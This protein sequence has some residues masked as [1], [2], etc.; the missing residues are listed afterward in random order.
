MPMKFAVI[1]LCLI[2]HISFG[3]FDEYRSYGDNDD[4][5]SRVLF[6]E[7]LSHFSESFGMLIYLTKKDYP[8]AQ[9]MLG[10]ISQDFNKAKNRLK[11]YNNQKLKPVMP[12]VGYSRSFLQQ[13]LDAFFNDSSK[14]LRKKEEEKKNTLNIF[15]LSMFFHTALEH[16]TEG[17]YLL[18]IL[19]ERDYEP[20]KEFQSHFEERIGGIMKKFGVPVYLSSGELNQKCR[21]I[22]ANYFTPDTKKLP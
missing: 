4:P 14:L 3:L 6:E 11:D 17:L 5:N 16:L 10:L 18:D 21:M 13:V 20:A 22:F 19:K 8:P 12:S 2:P 1:L 9:Q 15:S 7:T